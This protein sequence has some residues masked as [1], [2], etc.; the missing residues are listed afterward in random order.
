MKD[1]R[2]V[3]GTCSKSNVRYYF[4]YNNKV[5]FI[6]QKTDDSEKVME[7]MTNIRYA[8]EKWRTYKNES[9]DAAKNNTNHSD[10]EN[11]KPKDYSY[12]SMTFEYEA[13][14]PVKQGGPKNQGSKYQI[15]KIGLSHDG[16]QTK[17]APKHGEFEYKNKDDKVREKRYRDERF[18]EDKERH[19]EERRKEKKNGDY[20]SP[21]K[22][23]YKK[24]NTRFEK[25]NSYRR[26]ERRQDKSSH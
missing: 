20:I 24:N 3:L 1:I 19:K 26:N 15:D 7:K 2:F 16:K 23:G 22:K 17:F 8:Y 5:Y 18:K 14:M 4:Q 13:D 25:N 12:T 6:I 21:E 9:D 10:E 11:D